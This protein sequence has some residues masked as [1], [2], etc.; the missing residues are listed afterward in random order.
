MKKRWLRAIKILS[1]LLPVLLVVT[2]AQSYLFHFRER[3]VLRVD[4]FR[5]EEKNSLDVVFIGASDIYTGFS[6]AYAY[7]RY[8][9]TSYPYTTA[10]CPVLLWK[11]ML[12][13]TLSRQTPQLIVVEVNGVVYSKPE[14]LHNNAPMHYVL[15]NMPLSWNKI[16]TVFECCNEGTDPVLSFFFP[17]I[18]YHSMWQDAD[19]LEANYLDIRAQHKRG[20]TLLRGVSSTPKIAPELAEFRDVTE[21]FTESEMAE[22][23]EQAL[24]EFLEYCREKELNVLFTR[25]PHQIGF[26]DKDPVYWNYQITNRAE[27]IIQ[28]YGFPFLNLE[29]VTD[30]IGLDMTKD[31][32]NENHL[33]IDGQ[34][35]VTEYLSQCLISEFG[36]APRP[37]SAENQAGW[38][39]STEYYRLYCDFIKQQMGKPDPR[40]TGETAELIETLDAMKKSA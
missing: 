21:D 3:D 14:D 29:R 11:T 13:E 12:E 32:Y 25:F 39:V 17:I 38:E 27:R 19:E 15:D 5:L 37:Q 22:E 4:G 30:E 8:G 9:F 10:G 34:R 24:I 36:V 23:A 28:E 6:S 1:I 2:A 33:N 40:A 7:D 31:F 16:R 20:Y 35:K 26:G 18:K